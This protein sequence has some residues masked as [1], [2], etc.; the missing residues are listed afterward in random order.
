M[1]S[2]NYGKEVT[3][4]WEIKVRRI[5]IN[6]SSREYGVAR[7]HSSRGVFAA[8]IAVIHPRIIKTIC[9]LKK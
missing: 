6:D 9:R 4:V 8:I 2:Q 5:R 3:K 1:C 7:F